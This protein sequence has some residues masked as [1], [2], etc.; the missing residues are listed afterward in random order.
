MVRKQTSVKQAKT[1]DGS[2]PLFIACQDGHDSIVEALLGHKADVNKASTDDGST[3]LYAACEEGHV[4]I[5][6]ALLGHKADV[7]E[8]SKDGGWIHTVV[9]CLQKPPHIMRSAIDACSR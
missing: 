9:R 2:T 4:S 1:E 3:A 8:A 5:V 6:E 7:S